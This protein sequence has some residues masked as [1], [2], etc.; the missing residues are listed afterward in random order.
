MTKELKIKIKPLTRR[1]ICGGKKANAMLKS[2]F[3]AIWALLESLQGIWLKEAH[4]LL[5]SLCMGSNVK[6][7]TGWWAA[8]F[9]EKITITMLSYVLDWGWVACSAR[10]GR[11]RPGTACL[12]WKKRFLAG[13][14]PIFLGRWSDQTFFES[15]N[16]TK[17]ENICCCW[18]FVKTKDLSKIFVK[19][20]PSEV[21]IGYKTQFLKKIW[22][23]LPQGADSFSL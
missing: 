2:S 1:R 6:L 8:E 18:I 13:G 15:S 17:T 14:F 19:N 20:V 21:W 9:S 10:R 4:I 16:K 22:W 7:C 23:C 5:C 11:S 12:K 3:A